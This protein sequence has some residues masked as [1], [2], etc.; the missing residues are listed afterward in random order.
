MFV[1][2]CCCK[3]VLNCRYY[4][5]RVY[6]YSF[7]FPTRNH[8]R[9]F[10]KRRILFRSNGLFFR[11]TNERNERLVLSYRYYTTYRYYRTPCHRP[12][13]AALDANRGRAVYLPAG[14]HRINEKLYLSGDQSGLFGPGRIIQTN[15]DRVILEIEHASQVQLRDITLTRA[16]AQ[17]A[18]TGS[19]IA[20]LS[21]SPSTPAR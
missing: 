8:V 7:F 9:L 12:I 3:F 11:G 16:V 17:T 4:R 18:V 14:D 2:C 6:I 20:A 15:V 13:Q 21:E 1:D 10:G 5:S 19:R